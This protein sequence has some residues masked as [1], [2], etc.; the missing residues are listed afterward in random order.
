MNNGYATYNEVNFN[1]SNPLKLVV[2]LYD[3]AIN[4]LNKAI[5]YMNAGDIKNKNIYANK[6]RD[7]IEELNNSLNAE[8]GQELAQNLRRLY[9]FMN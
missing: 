6:A 2:M 3:G 5:E 8:Q 4:Y 1:T 9:F 7:I